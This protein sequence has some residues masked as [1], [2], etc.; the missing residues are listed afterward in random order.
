MA[1]PHYPLANIGV[2]GRLQ[3]VCRRL[4]SRGLCAARLGKPV[5]ILRRELLPGRSGG[6]VPGPCD[7]AVAYIPFLYDLLKPASIDL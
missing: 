5:P 1:K 4:S 6:N 7:D 3:E 2:S